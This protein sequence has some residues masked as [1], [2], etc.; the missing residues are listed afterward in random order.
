LPSHESLTDDARQAESWVDR[1]AA[2]TKAKR[3][4]KA[5][6]HLGE[7]RVGGT[8]PAGVPPLPDDFA[9]RIADGTGNAPTFAEALAT[10]RVLAAIGYETAAPNARA[11]TRGRRRHRFQSAGTSAGSEQTNRAAIRARRAVAQSPAALTADE[12]E[13]QASDRG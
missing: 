1:L 2:N 5:A 7:V 3:A 13:F 10:Q 12:L 9:Q 6:T 11:L 8:Q 4:M